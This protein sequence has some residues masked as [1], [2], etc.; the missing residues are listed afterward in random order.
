MV[1]GVIIITEEEED[2]IIII[3]NH[4]R[5]IIPLRGVQFH[6]L[7]IIMIVIIKVAVEA[8]TTTL[9]VATTAIIMV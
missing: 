7:G 5:V 4:Q 9:E 8:I 1:L 2:Q 3:I 6:H